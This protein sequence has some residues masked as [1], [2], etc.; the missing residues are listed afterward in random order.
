MSPAIFI[1]AFLFGTGAIA[2]WV[3]A[4]FPRL[5]PSDLR[6]ALLRS[7][8]A[9]VGSQLVFTPAWDAAVASGAILVALFAVAFPCLGYLCLSTIWSI[10][11]LQAAMHGPS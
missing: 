7:G 5:A 6:R 11:R 10:R 8:I 2:L 1:I 3:D 9:L 4:R